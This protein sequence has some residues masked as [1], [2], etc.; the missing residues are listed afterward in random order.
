MTSNLYGMPRTFASVVLVLLCAP[1]ALPARASSPTVLARG[2]ATHAYL[3]FLSEIDRHFDVLRAASSSV[4]TA[5]R[6]A[7]AH[8]GNGVAAAP[9]DHLLRSTAS[10]CAA[11]GLLLSSG[12]QLVPPGTIL[13]NADYAYFERTAIAADDVACDERALAVD[14][15]A[16]I[17]FPGNSTADERA[18]NRTVVSDESRY[19]HTVG[20][21]LR[22]FGYTQIAAVKLLRSRG[23][24]HSPL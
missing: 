5:L 8:P 22:H 10:E 21:T 11:V 19:F 3:L 24:L 13:A 18:D 9:L 14:L 1:H 17:Q 6:R 15:E 16:H 20:A 23:L 7:A 12:I 4:L 2:P